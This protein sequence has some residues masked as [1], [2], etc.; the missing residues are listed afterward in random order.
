MPITLALKF[1]FGIAIKSQNVKSSLKK[2]VIV[3]GA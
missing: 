2:N 1:Q 3:K